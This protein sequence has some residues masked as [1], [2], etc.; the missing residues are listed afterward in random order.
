[1]LLCPL[2]WC[3]RDIEPCNT[4]TAR[5]L[6]ES[7]K[8]RQNIPKRPSSGAADALLSAEMKDVCGA[9]AAGRW[10]VGGGLEDGSCGGLLYE[11]DARNGFPE[12]MLKTRS[13]TLF[14]VRGGSWYDAAWSNC[15]ARP[16]VLMSSA[17]L[18][19][20]ICW[21]RLL[22]RIYPTIPHEPLLILIAER[23]KDRDLFISDVCKGLLLVEHLRTISSLQLMASTMLFIGSYPGTTSGTLKIMSRSKQQE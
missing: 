4:I 3:T 20:D 1:M 7:T 16:L 5:L 15:C 17:F 10:E 13:N 6:R 23:S 9:G 14:Y 22:S 12:D 19:A 11:T 21:Q 8:A 2:R 18:E